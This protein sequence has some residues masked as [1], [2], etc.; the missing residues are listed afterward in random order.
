MAGLHAREDGTECGYIA[1]GDPPAFCTKCGW[2]PLRQERDDLRALL[3]T[4]RDVLWTINLDATEYHQ[5]GPMVEW[6]DRVLQ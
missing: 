6:I 5:A 2:T 3:R 4:T 1:L